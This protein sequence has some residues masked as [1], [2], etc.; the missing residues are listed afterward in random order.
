[1]S[2]FTEQ[3]VY[4]ASQSE[5]KQYGIDS[6]N[7]AQW[8]EGMGWP[9]WDKQIDIL[10]ALVHHDRVASPASFGVGK[11]YLA[12]RTALHFGASHISSKVITT[13]PTFRQVR[14]LLW[15]ELRQA[16]NTAS[17][18]IGGTLLTTRLDFMDN[19]Y[20]VGFS[21]KDDDIEKFT[22]YHA[23]H[24]LV[25]FDQ[26][27]GISRAAWEAAEGLMT[28]SH[29]KW[30]VISNT[31]DDQS[32]M[33]DIC[34]PDRNHF[35]G[36]W[37]IIRINAFDS[38]NV[39]AGKDIIPGLISAKWLETKKKVWRVEDP[40]W[41]IFV[42]AN[43]VEAATMTLF[44]SALRK[45]M[46]STILKPDFDLIDIGVDPADEGTDSTVLTA[47][48]G[49]RLLCIE[50]F[51]GRNPMKVVKVVIDFKKKIERRVNNSL[52][53][54]EKEKEVRLIKVD[55]IGVGSGVVA[56]LGE[57]EYPVHGVVVSRTPHDTEQFANVR[58][59]M[60]WAF[61]DLAEE[62]KL[63]LV[64]LWHTDPL[65]LKHLNEECSVQYK[66]NSS[67]RILLEPK[68]SIKKRIKRSPDFFDS[69]V[70]C[71]TEEGSLPLVSFVDI[72]EIEKD[73]KKADEL[74]TKELK[75][76]TEEQLAE[77]DELFGNVIPDDMF[78]GD[79]EEWY[80]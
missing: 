53:E 80:D 66:F 71:Y 8:M 58:A 7:P 3:E 16:Y 76:K 55:K 26:A 49:Q 60:G 23:P 42:E 29:C 41:Q 37:K 59:E 39:K 68:D 9:L 21:T 38:P 32:V 46:F 65:A 1:M 77:L 73:I 6:D 61:K 47:R 11:T 54:N 79:E 40:M 56:R 69:A 36:D 50:H 62:G 19:H 48:A 30:L 78:E 10:N 28:S 2:V 14:D 4:Q 45:K 72:L 20:I 31:T 63:S 74:A 13:A 17:F 75:Q 27:C 52:K 33:A 51:V 44:T 25:I 67:G 24:V 64:P 18:R 15:A 43:F 35:F 12:A 22:G 70:M 5:A 57:L 34:M